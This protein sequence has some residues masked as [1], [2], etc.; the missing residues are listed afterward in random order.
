VAVNCCVALVTRVAVVGL[1]ETVP[2]TFTVVL[3]L[4]AVSATLVAAIV[5][6]PACDGAVYMPVALIVPLVA[7]PPATPSTDH[8]TPVLVMPLIVAVNCCVPDCATVAPVGATTNENTVTAAV[9]LSAPLV[10][11]AAPMLWFP[12]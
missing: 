11:L 4:A 5:C 8:V 9:A 6:A 10:V 3:T 7:F 2:E 1:I 12:D